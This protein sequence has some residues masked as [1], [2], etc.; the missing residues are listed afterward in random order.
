MGDH[1]QTKDFFEDFD[2]GLHKFAHNLHG[3]IFLSLRALTNG[4]NEIL[5][6]GADLFQIFEIYFMLR[7]IYT[8]KGNCHIHIF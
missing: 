1:L 6:V 3:T 2:I 7:Q 4:T 5:N 8:L